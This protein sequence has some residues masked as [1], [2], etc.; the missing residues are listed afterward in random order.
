MVF[1]CLIRNTQDSGNFLIGIALRDTIQYLDLSGRE[2]REHSLVCLVHMRE[3]AELIK[4]AGRHKWTRQDILVDE[5]F[6]A[7]NPADQLDDLFG[8]DVLR[9]VGR[10]AD[11]NR[12]KELLV[13]L[14]HREDDHPG[15]WMASFE[16]SRDFKS[17]HLRHVDINENDVR[18]Q[19][20]RLLNTGLTVAGFADDENIGFIFKAPTHAASKQRMIINDQDLDAIHGSPCLLAAFGLH[21]QRAG[22][23]SKRHPQCDSG[24]FSCLAFELDVSVDQ[25][26]A[27]SHA[28]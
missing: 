17:A 7:S 26:G 28:R 22:M 5:V 8:F 18:N 14:V 3:L 20:V 6:T 2:R 12:V 10:R 9:A 21:P 4:H 1:H 15:L 25:V 13:I 19:H 24:A 11:T 16:D 27:F 23:A